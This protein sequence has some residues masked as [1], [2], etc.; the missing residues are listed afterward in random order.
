MSVPNN[1]LEDPLVAAL[2]PNTDYITYLTILEYQ[3]TPKNLS[4]LNRLLQEDDGTLA[5]EIGWDLL[6]LVLP[7]L[8]VEPTKA[9]ECLDIIARRGN[10]REVIVRVSEEL[11]TLGIDDDD[12]DGE[13]DP[14][15][16]TSDIPTFA[17][18]APH[19]HLGEMTLAGMPAI[20]KAQPQSQRDDEHTPDLAIEE[21]KLQSL[22]SMLSSLHPRIKTQY[23][24]RFL[25]TSLPAALGAYRR[26][27]MNADSTLAFLNTL[28]KLSGRARP[29]L[30][31]RVPT[32]DMLKQS[33]TAGSTSISSAPLPDPESKSESE[34]VSQT[35]PGNEEAINQRLLQAVLLEVLEEFTAASSEA[36]P[37]LTARLRTLYQPQSLS[38]TRKIELDALVTSGPAA[39][40]DTLRNRFI[41]ASKDLKMDVQVEVAK[42]LEPSTDGLDPEEEHEYPTSPSQI[43]IAG[44]GLVLLYGVQNFAQARSQSSQDRSSTVSDVDTNSILQLVIS[45]YTSDARL[46]QS[47]PA[48]D[49]FLS[50]LYTF[51]CTPSVSVTSDHTDQILLSTFTLLKDIFTTSPDPDLRDNAYHIAT[52]LLHAHFS[53]PARKILIKDLLTTSDSDIS[54]PIHE[55]QAGTLKALAVSWLKDEIYPTATT[56][57]IMQALPNPSNRGLPMSA[58]VDLVDVLFPTDTIPAPP[59]INSPPDDQATDTFAS[60]IPFY[61]AALNLL[62]VF[63][64][65]HNQQ[66]TE[67]SENDASNTTNAELDPLIAEI[68]LFLAK[69]EGWSGYLTAQLASG[70]EGVDEGEVD[71]IP[72]ADVFALEDAVGRARVVVVG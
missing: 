70:G 10:P 58:L 24:S 57:T 66:P 69:L 43:P 22:L 46:R 25:A 40:A 9:K 59:A 29:S 3:L 55:A 44:T 19:V 41:I 63:I 60:E 65:N 37:P 32:A 27:S 26:L 33:T 6:K 67:D 20:E 68:A 8:R 42:L 16:S 14:T 62:C 61:I 31:P 17:G 45:Q 23:P 49:C 51:F 56:T 71:G 11:E 21:L 72:I 4:T 13:A 1:T 48:L 18:E 12:E 38:S 7:I 2:P 34:S 39:L 50:I 5:S 35:A 15:E 53:P 54:S 52:H 47:A 64:R 30:P 36:Q 28:V